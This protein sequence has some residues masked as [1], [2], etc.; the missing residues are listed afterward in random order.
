MVTEAR[1]AQCQGKLW[2]SG[3]TDVQTVRYAWRKGRKTNRTIS[4]LV[5]TSVSLRKAGVEQL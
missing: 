4:Q 5:P 1:E 2:W 3:D